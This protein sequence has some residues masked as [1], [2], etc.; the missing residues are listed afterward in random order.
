MRS[1]PSSPVA[2]WRRLRQTGGRRVTIIDLYNLVAAPRGL[3]AH[4][5][6]LAERMGLAQSVLPDIWPGFELTD[7]SERVGDPIRIVDHN[8]EWHALFEQWRQRLSADLGE[9]AIRIEHVGSTSVHG[10]PA[11]PIVDIQISV[12]DLEDESSY[13][14]QLEKL[15]NQLRSRDEL[16]RYFRPFPT[17]PRDRH[18][19]VCASGSAWER[20]HLLFRDYLRAHAGAREE[21]AAAKRQAAAMWADDGWAYTDAKTGV[22]LNIL[23]DAKTWAT[24]T[25]TR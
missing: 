14:P 24:T 7:N 12:R 11:K 10:L 3:A 16:H 2:R 15:G 21:Y 19:H 22:I 6:P 4:E 13:T 18:I 17:F 25:P 23:D 9:T 5:L 20:E 1:A 8:P